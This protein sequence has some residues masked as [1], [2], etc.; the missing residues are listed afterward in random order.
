LEKKAKAR[1]KMNPLRKELTDLSLWNQLTC[2]WPPEIS[3]RFVFQKFLGK[4]SFA[5]V[6]SVLDFGS[7]K[8]KHKIKKSKRL[9][10][11]CRAIK[12]LHKQP[13]THREAFIWKFLSHLKSPYIV[14]C[15]LSE[16]KFRHPFFVLS[17][18]DATL[19]KWVTSFPGNGKLPLYLIKSIVLQILK[20]LLTLHSCC[21]MH[22]DL[23]L[24]N[25]LIRYQE[26]E[27]GNSDIKATITDFGMACMIPTYFT[28]GTKAYNKFLE[29]NWNETETQRGNRKPTTS[30]VCEDD[31]KFSFTSEKNKKILN[32][33]SFPLTTKVTAAPYRAPE[34]LLGKTNYTQAI[35]IWAVGIILGE[36]ILRQRLW[37]TN[38]E[39]EQLKQIY[40][41]IGTPSRELYFFEHFE[42]FQVYYL[43][44][45]EGWSIEKWKHVFGLD[46]NGVD[47]MM[48]LLEF[49]PEKRITASEAL[50]HPWFS[51]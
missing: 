43:Q 25:I 17:Q 29:I 46:R 49:D 50:L 3:E 36:L 32:E 48:R 4:G 45:H 27:K 18:K 23:S 30:V 9:K 37:S 34:V 51:E 31:R 10:G 14:S 24:C 22:R 7:R 21:I 41:M 39:E 19:Q 38:L 47:L 28:E 20:G 5:Y 35:D 42:K 1:N 16:M 11:K 33:R 2:D 13:A 40:E 8:E 12:F 26:E 44:Q 15:Y 6:F